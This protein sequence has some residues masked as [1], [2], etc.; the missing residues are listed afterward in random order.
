MYS[1]RHIE[2]TAQ[3]RIA[4]LERRVQ[5]EEAL[6]RVRARA[7]KMRRSNDLAGVIDIIRQEL[8][9][10]GLDVNPGH[11]IILGGRRQHSTFSFFSLRQQPHGSSK[12]LSEE[13]RVILNRFD[14][15]FEQAYTRYQDLKKAEAHAL[16]AERQSSLDRVRAEIISMRTAEDLERITPLIWRELTLLGVPF[17]RCGVFIL[18]DESKT[19]QSFLTTPDGEHL[20][21][22]LIPFDS[23]ETT[24]TAVEHWRHGAV[25][26]D[27]W[28]RQQFIDWSRT[29]V[30]RGHIDEARQMRGFGNPPESLS[31]HFAPFSQ[32]M[33]YVGSDAPLSSDQL[34][35][36]QSLTDTFSV[37]YAR[38]E[39]FQQLESKNRELATTLTHLKT[40]QAQLIQQEKMASLGQLSAGI[41]HEI[42]N[43]LNF[44]NNFAQLLIEILDEMAEEAAI[45]GDNQDSETI[46]I[47]KLNASKIH[48]HG[49]RADRIVE[50]MMRHTSGATGQR[51]K[52][53]L[54]RFVDGYVNLALHSW[55]T[56]PQTRRVYIGKTSEP[57]NTEDTAGLRGQN[58]PELSTN[59]KTSLQVI[60]DYSDDAGEIN[61]VPQELGQVLLN[62]I[63]NAF[64]AMVEQSARRN[65]EYRPQLVVSTRRTEDSVEIR[66]TDNGVGIP[67]HVRD[68]VFEPFFT[69]KPTGS[70]TGLGLSLSYDI[71]TKGHGGYLELESKEGQ[72]TTLIVRLPADKQ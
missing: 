62:L 12:C 7:T 2:L 55:E 30:A 34:D 42:K 41:A 40:T 3:T 45:V 32:G 23:S 5:V 18:D 49:R 21:S 6:E 66:T 71:V 63:N 25:F 8:S 37:A 58:T 65:G 44:V 31:L 17:F 33:L 70:G 20:A 29:L 46:E 53:D 36:V 50:S 1:S 51:R 15:V 57:E 13:D 11:S 38:Y 60:R 26:T 43:P 35:L 22:L 68:R 27:Q 47:L 14:T 69:T 4:E 48:E 61:L 52:V 59:T 9:K 64:D 28:D 67:D 54:N 19:I 24:R 10:L 39:D 16:E 56:H 72:G